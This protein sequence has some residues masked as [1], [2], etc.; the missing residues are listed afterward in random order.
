MER[1]A[2]LHRYGVLDTPRESDFDDIVA[3][4]SEICDAPISVINLIDQDRQW[5]KAEVGLGVRE[6]P[7]DTSLCA[8][9]ILEEEFLEIEDTLADQRTA[10]NPLCAGEPGLR[11]YAGA[12]L[13][14]GDGLPL[15]T[16]CVLDTT[17]RR[18]SPLQINA[19]RVLAAQV[20]T[21]LELRLALRREAALRRESD[22]RVK[23][24]LT[25]ITA[26]VRIQ[27]RQAASDETRAALGVVRQRIDTV[28]ALHGLLYQTKTEGTIC[29][30]EYLAQIVGL[31][32]GTAPEGVALSLDVA[33][34]QLSPAV[35]GSVAVIVN[36][37]CTNAFKHAF[38]H[39]NGG[40]VT[41][42]GTAEPGKSYILT[43]ADDGVGLAAAA[44]GSNAAQP[45]IGN[46]IIEASVAQFG[47]KLEV[48]PTD[49][50][51]AVQIT[52]PL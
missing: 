18:L 21:Q 44:N 33:R 48:V 23:N 39:G 1:L 40:T 20:M 28:A 46:A 45:G 52:V 31:L 19:L 14:T 8:H 37:L 12:L 30:A 32:R 35:A 49:I 42:T 50:G 17:P 36:E 4:A 29:L 11:Y 51:R 25:A 26:L 2:A 24:S 22:H 15:G 47:G 13:R 9:A 34:V 6:T 5:F 16:L 7:L 43:C 27:G 10:S 3:L 41:L 38:P